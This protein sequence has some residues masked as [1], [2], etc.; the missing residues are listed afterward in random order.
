MR[1]NLTREIV[2]S[3]DYLRTN[4][5]YDPE[6]G[7]LTLLV[8]RGK[9]LPGHKYAP[10]V[11]IKVLGQVVKRSRISW[12]IYYGEEPPELIDHRDNDTCNNRIENLRPATE[13]TNG[14]NTRVRCDSVSGL[15]GAFYVPRKKGRK[16]YYSKIRVNIGDV[17]YLGWFETAMEAHLAYMAAA[18]KYFGEFANNGVR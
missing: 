5:A 2:A 16:K 17:R 11:S 15:K 4:F 6:T 12:K 18:H 9:Y 7:D 1:D 3:V 14:R 8:R 13:Q 10:G